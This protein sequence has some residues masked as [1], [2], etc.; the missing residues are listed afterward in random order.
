MDILDKYGYIALAVLGGIAALAY[1]IW[2]IVFIDT[3]RDA[4]K[5]GK[6]NRDALND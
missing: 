1:I 2:V 5:R 4:R 6:R 3:I